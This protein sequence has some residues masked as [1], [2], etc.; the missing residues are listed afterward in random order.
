MRYNRFYIGLSK[1]GRPY[2]FVVFRPQK[3][4]VRIELKLPRTDD[5]DKFIESAGLEALEYYARSGIYRISLKKDD[6]TN[7]R[8]QLKQLI[9]AAYK[10]RTEH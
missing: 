10:N 7:K 6:V 2:N 3:T 9:E 1:N 8:E 4:T 5:T